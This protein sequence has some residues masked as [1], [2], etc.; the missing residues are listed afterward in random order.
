MK[1]AGEVIDLLDK[2]VIKDLQFKSFS[3]SNDTS[4]KMLLGITFV[5]SKEYTAKLSAE[6]TERVLSVAHTSINQSMAM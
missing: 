1:E 3:F 6:V 2:R 4:G 5:L